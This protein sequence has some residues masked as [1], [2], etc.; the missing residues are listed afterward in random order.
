LIA[1]GDL[2]ANRFTT[3]GTH[4]APLMGI[5]PTGRSMTVHGFEVHRIQDGKVAETWV[6]DDV[7]GIL[8]QLGV[9]SPPPSMGPPR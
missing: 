1:D 4:R 3:R 8:M 9:V 5:P 6:A 7:P 2:V